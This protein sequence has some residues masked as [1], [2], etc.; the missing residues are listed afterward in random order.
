MSTEMGTVTLDGG[1][2]NTV[3]AIGP[4]GESLTAISSDSMREPYK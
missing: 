2:G 4:A 3:E 1:E